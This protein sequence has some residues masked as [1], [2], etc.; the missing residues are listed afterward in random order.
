[1]E[2]I[3]SHRLLGETRKKQRDRQNTG[4]KLNRYKREKERHEIAEGR[5][6]MMLFVLV[7]RDVSRGSMIVKAID[8]IDEMT[9]G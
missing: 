1:M 8:P 4:H 5:K 2:K 9:V 3:I 6:G 7:S